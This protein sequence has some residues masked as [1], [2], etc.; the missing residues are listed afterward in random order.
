MLGGLDQVEARVAVAGLGD[1]SFSLPRPGR[2]L[3]GGQAEVGHHGARRE[4]APHVAELGGKAGGRQPARASERHQRADQRVELPAQAEDLQLRLELVDAVAGMVD[5]ADVALHR[6][7][8]RRV[9]HDLLAQVALVLV[10]PAR[11]AQVAVAVAKQERLEPLPASPLV[12]LGVEAGAAQVPDGLVDGVRHVD[13]VELPAAV[14]PRQGAGVAPVGLDPVSGLLGHVR[15]RGDDAVLAP[16]AQ[17]PLQD[18]AGRA[19][20]VGEVQLGPSPAEALHQLP[21][22]VQPAG[23]RPQVLDFAAPPAVGEGDDGGFLVDIHAH[24]DM[25]LSHALVSLVLFSLYMRPF[26]ANA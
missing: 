14:G 23:D 24:V 3:G 4:E 19:G 6:R 21:D 12:L 2:V 25:L 16:R 1:R 9:L 15:G 7:L 20:L 11:L 5:G 18:E 17:A 8:L 22:R 10:G 26:R 13:G